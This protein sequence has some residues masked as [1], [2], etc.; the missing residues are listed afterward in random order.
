MAAASASPALDTFPRL[1]LH[2]AEVR[3]GSAGH[4]REGPRHLADVDVVAG[5]RRSARARLRIGGARLQAR[6]EPRDHRRQPSAPVLDDGGGAGAGR[7]AGSALPGC[8]R[9]GNGLRAQRRGH[10]VRRR[11]GPGAGR[12]AARDTRPLP[13]SRAHRLRRPAGAAPLHAGLPPRLRRG[14]GDGPRPPRYAPG[15]LPGGSR[16]GQV[17]GRVPSW[18]TRPARPASRRVSASPTPR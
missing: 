7:R 11:R 4:A 6:D 1:L 10:P 9:R 15:F 16:R 8:R 13:E 2:H 17:R 3:G 18:S 5:G 12:Q 14:P